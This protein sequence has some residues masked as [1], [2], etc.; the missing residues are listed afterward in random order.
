MIII[1]INGRM[2]GNSTTTCNSP[3]AACGPERQ[4]DCHYLGRE[5]S[6][7]QNFGKGATTATEVEPV[8]SRGDVEP[9][10]ECFAS[11]AGPTAHPPFI[12]LP[13]DENI[14]NFAHVMCLH[15]IVNAKAS[16]I[17]DRAGVGPSQKG[18]LP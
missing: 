17:R 2:R 10:E 5:A 11:E 13:I 4:I 7:R 18:G 12:C 1:A 14:A 8:K 3:N 16:E 9:V 6:C 15:Q